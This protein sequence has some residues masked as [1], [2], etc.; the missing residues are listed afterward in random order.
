MRHLGT[1]LTAIASLACAAIILNGCI[2]RTAFQDQLTR[3]GPLRASRDSHTYVSTASKPL[4]VA[5]IDTR[6]DETVWSI[7]VP[8]GKQLSM[9]FHEGK[10]SDDEFMPD[11]VTWGLFRPGKQFGNRAQSQP[12]PPSNARLLDVSVRESAELPE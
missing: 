8:L 7:D 4:T 1:H 12:V 11:L 5:V 2:V 6:T 9:K 3:K 10:G